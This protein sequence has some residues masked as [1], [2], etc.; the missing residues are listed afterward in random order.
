LPPAGRG[1]DLL[2]HLAE[3]FASEHE[4]TYGHKAEGDPIQMV[5]L[6]LTARVRRGADR[7]DM[8]LAG[9][10]RG[11]RAHRS[12]YFGPAHGGIRTPVI[13]RADL[14]SRARP[15]PLLIDEYDATT[16]V[17]PGCRAHLDR[18]G[19]IVIATGG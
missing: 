1:D 10:R 12:A 16:L 14:G 5:N 8:R 4:R 7:R 15:G 6:R 17:P 2:H 3:A 19:N 11:R 18:H 9:E 13:G